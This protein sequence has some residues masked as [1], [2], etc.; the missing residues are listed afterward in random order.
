MRKTY[1]PLLAVLGLL[2]AGLGVFAGPAQAQD[3]GP[4]LLINAGFE[5]GH[6]NQDGI[7]EIVVPNGWRMHW[8]DNELIFGG[9]WPSARP[10]TVVWNATGGVPAGEEIFWRDG[11][12]T[13]KVF[14]AY[15]PM[16]AAISQDVQGLEVGRKYRLSVPMFIDIFEDYQNG[17][18]IPPFRKDSGKVRLG[19]SPVGAAWRDESAIQ[20]SGWWTAD[21]VDPFYQAMPT[22]VYDFV[23]TQPNMTIWIEMASSYP[24]PNNGF[25]YDLPGLFALNETAPVAAPPAAP[26]QGQAA[27]PAVAAQPAATIVPPTPRADGAIVHVVQ[28]GDSL[29]GIAIQYASVLGM[30]PED[31]LPYI[32]D[33]N[34][35]PAFINPGD[36]IL[37][38]AANA[39]SPTPETAAG[40]EATDATPD[41]NAT[42]DEAA[43]ALAEGDAS[44]ETA[45]AET[46]AVE[47]TTDFVPVEELAGTICVATF[48]DANADGQRNEGEA[49]VADA[50]IALAR[51]GTTVS[52][53]ITDGASE[54]Y[55]F[56][57]TQADSYQLQLYPPAGFAATTED[58]WA[59]AIDNGESYTVSFGLTAAP[60]LADASRTEA[61]D[62]AANQPAAV[63]E[64]TA[65]AD[66]GGLGNLGLIIVGVA[67]VLVVL[68]VIGVVLLRRG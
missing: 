68:A 54:P 13:M 63:P 18:K 37:I 7:A 56:E 12:Y 59:V 40:D 28:S 14:K 4:N 36:E 15:A 30:T 1:L 61:V 64:E 60:E 67:A 6:F 51:G 43:G 48:D 3:L 11:I 55:C 62:T 57:L 16:W 33:L 39:A 53:Y 29:W 23:A 66:S 27:P 35:N 17:R 46:P 24:Y 8:S 2:L 42:P 65:P 9:E 20:Y 5:E 21:T 25:F 32:R 58:N 22:F 50:A 44:A 45:V 38:Q 52:N 49:L 10:E 19:A 31:A 26:A 34:N 47:P 41:P